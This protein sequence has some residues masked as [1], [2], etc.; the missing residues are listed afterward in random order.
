MRAVCGRYVAAMGR[1]L[2]FIGASPALVGAIGT[3]KEL[4]RN[5]PLMLPRTLERAEADARK[6]R[7]EAPSA[8]PEEA[9][10]EEPRADEALDEEEEEEQE[11]EEKASDAEEAP[12]AAED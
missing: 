5:N 2:D 9:P 6:A 12:E 4:L 3:P 1:D 10:A 8:A 11:Q 7:D